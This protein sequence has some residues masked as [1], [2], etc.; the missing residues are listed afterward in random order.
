[1]P[2]WLKTLINLLAPAVENLVSLSSAFQIPSDNDDSAV[3]LALG[4]LLK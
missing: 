1:L 2:E 4:M 3:N